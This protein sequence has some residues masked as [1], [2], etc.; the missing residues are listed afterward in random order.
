MIFVNESLARGGG[1]GNGRGLR[2]LIG[3]NKGT[4]NQKVHKYFL[5]F[6]VKQ[7]L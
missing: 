5:L 6:S 4:K 1:I 3:G 2:A 7:F